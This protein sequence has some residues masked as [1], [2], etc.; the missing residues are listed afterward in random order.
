MK[1][2]FFFLIPVLSISLGGYSLF[3]YSNGDPIQ[4]V[5]TKSV[6]FNGPDNSLT[7]RDEPS[8]GEFEQERRINERTH[9]EEFLDA[10]D[11]V[12]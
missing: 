2:P 11:Q 10:K 6:G 8:S 1:N 5:E 4:A 12:D 3:F 7:I 9:P